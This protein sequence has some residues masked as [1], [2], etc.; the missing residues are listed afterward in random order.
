MLERLFDTV[1]SLGGPWAYLAVGLL[2]AGESSLGVG[3]VVPG[4]TAMIVG[5]FVVSRGN[6]TFGLMWL[7][8]VIGAVLGDSLGYEIGRRFG[9]RIRRTRLGRAVGDERWRRAEAYLGERGGRA[10]F[11]GRFVAVVRSVVPAVAGISRMP[12]PKFLMWNAAG[13]VLWAS[14]YVSLGYAA[15]R[16][17]ERVAD[18]AE[19]AGYVVLAL[20]ALVATVVLG[21]R[22]VAHHPERVAEW[23]DRLGAWRPVAFVRRRFGRPIHFARRRFQ[24]DEAFGLSLTVGLAFLIIT[25]WALATVASDVAARADLVG[26]DGPIARWF[27]DHRVEWLTDVMRRVTDLGSVAVLTPL[28][29]AVALAWLVL[30]RRW[31]V[32]LFLVVALLGAVVATDVLK[33]LLERPRPP[34]R[35][36]AATASGFAFPSGHTVQATVTF[37]ALAYLQGSVLRLWSARVA[38]WA[39]AALLSLLVGFSRAYLGVHWLSDVLGGYALGAAWLSLVITAFGTSTRFHRQYRQSA[40]I[41]SRAA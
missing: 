2:A 5:G 41:S 12:Y 15:G 29:V 30:T 39:G 32:V 38:V 27:A 26:L 19:G 24:L 23:G 14:I 22:W 35:L 3:L 11:F 31:G 6:A 34:L 4:E 40:S 18:A 36:A 13:A 9:G 20:V 25:A 21:A 37:G 10:V 33:D 7:V 1:G 17:Y 16:S 8:A 28:S